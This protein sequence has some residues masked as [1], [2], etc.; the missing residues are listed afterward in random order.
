MLG[1]LRRVTMVVRHH[2]TREI[3][4]KFL[5]MIARLVP[6]YSASGVK[7]T[8]V[9]QAPRY[10]GKD[11]HRVGSTQCICIENS[12][13]K[14]YSGEYATGLHLSAPCASYPASAALPDRRTPR[15]VDTYEASAPTPDLR[16]RM[17]RSVM[18]PG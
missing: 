4:T 11:F 2:L 9:V 16:L 6:L 10:S 12:I 7:I 13:E 5:L 8:I 15:G 17:C 1:P 14:S 3:V 18:C